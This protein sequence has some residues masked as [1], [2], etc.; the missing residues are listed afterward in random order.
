MGGSFDGASQS[1][2]DDISVIDRRVSSKYEV[3]AKLGKGAYGIVWKATVLERGGE[4]AVPQK[5]V[6]LKKIFDAFQ[7]STDAQ[8]TYREILYLKQMGEHENVVKL[9]NVLKAEND[10]DIY[11]VFEY[12]E[13]DLHAAILANILEDVH[14]QYIMHQ[15]FKALTY[16][17]SAGL[18]HHA[19]Q[20]LYRGSRCVRSSSRRVERASGWITAGMRTR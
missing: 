13:T 20:G 16:M 8:R 6:A 18:V 4:K 2:S 11:L 3:G 1:S 12:L 9:L 19:S 17:H 5:E 15:A 10:R 14:K 7:N